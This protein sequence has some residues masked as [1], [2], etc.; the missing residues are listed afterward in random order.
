MLRRLLGQDASTAQL[1]LSPRKVQ[2]SAVLAMM[3]ADDD[4]D[5][6]SSDESSDDD[7]SEE[8]EEVE[9]P[10][11]DEEQAA[12]PSGD[13][14]AEVADKVDVLDEPVSEAA[15]VND[16][17]CDV[18]QCAADGAIQATVVD[19]SG[20]EE[21][22]INSISADAAPGGTAIDNAAQQAAGTAEG[23][24]AIGKDIVE[25]EGGDGSRGGDDDNYDDEDYGSDFDDSYGS[26]DFDD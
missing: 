2:D 17:A 8:I 19:D 12:V 10:E 23:A 13:E 16:S 9:E 15:G 5:D 25:H 14:V 6:D 22:S 26:G 1:K 20:V 18:A 11:E 7:S 3:F 21:S 24:N 4:G